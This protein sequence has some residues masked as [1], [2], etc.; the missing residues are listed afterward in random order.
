[1][2][3]CL[4][5]GFNDFQ[6]AL[7]PGFLHTHLQKEQVA[8]FLAENVHH[9]NEQ[10]DVEI[11]V[12][13]A[14]G[15]LKLSA[16]IFEPR[17]TEI[18]TDHRLVSEVEGKPFQVV[19]HDCLPVGICGL[20]TT[21]LKRTCKNY[22]TDMV[23]ADAFIEEV[24][25]KD[26]TQIPRKILQ[27]V[28][29]Y[30]A[31]KTMPLVRSALMLYATHFYMRRVV[32][33][34]DESV[35]R[36]YQ[37]MGS[38][39]SDEELESYLSSRLLNRQ[40]KYVIYKIQ[41]ELTASVLEGLEKL[42]RSRARDSWAPSFCTILVLSL[43]I[44]HIETAA[45][46]FVVCDIA[47]EANGGFQSE[48]R[49]DQSSEACSELDNYPFRQCTQLFHDIFKSHREYNGGGKEAFN[50]LM[51]DV[52]MDENSGWDQA[53][54]EMILSIRQ[55]IRESDG[56]MIRLANNPTFLN[57]DFTVT[58]D[59]I[60]ANNTGRLVSKFLKSFYST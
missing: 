44:E 6:R 27:S 36:I 30:S 43:C 31:S 10:V 23:E 29:R 46:I 50:P 41:Q 48:Y 16:F 28:I 57:S 39:E 34:M 22:L 26:G 1:L 12:G 58:P 53:T 24:C 15:S 60:K 49:R 37:T 47:K 13:P 18:L 35:K 4:R 5:T 51:S 19:S 54:R 42:L 32:T 7:F 55:I 52:K 20:S 45:D 9:F 40:I 25:G 14:F 56:E 11:T 38:F 33:F 2:H 8:N 17:G 59:S 21:E 3:R